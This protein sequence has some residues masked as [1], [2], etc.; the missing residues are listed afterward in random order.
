MAVKKIQLFENQVVLTGAGT[1]GLQEQDVHVVSGSRLLV[2]LLVTA[3]DGGASVTL[4]IKNTFES[5]N[6]YETIDTIVATGVGRTKK[7][8]SDFHNLF[9]FAVTVTG[10]NASYKVGI[11]MADNAMTTRIEN[12]VIEVELDAATDSVTVAAITGPV[13]LPTGAS[14]EAKQDVGNA[15]LESLDN[16]KYT[17]ILPVLANS[18]FLKLGNFDQIVPTFLG[19]VAT[20]SY[21]EDSAKI[22]D[23]VITFQ[24]NVNWDM[25]LFAYIN[26]DDGS[27]LEEDD[28]SSLLLE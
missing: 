24:S 5:D 27:I 22:A 15:F 18:R 11:A 25:D 26:D 7:I 10:G 23:A 13:A 2:S 20:L 6:G 16:G 9:Q 17:A 12:A 28:G 8:Y 3:L 4:A 21:Y 14:T 1:T 19:D